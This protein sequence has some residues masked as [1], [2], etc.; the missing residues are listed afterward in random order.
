VVALDLEAA[1]VAAEAVAAHS[2]V[3]GLPDGYREQDPA[4]WISA[5][6]HA[7]REVLETLGDARGGVAGIGI[8]APTGGMVV[9]DESNRIVRPA[10]LGI[11]RSAQRQADE[12][13]RAF[14]GAPGLLELCGNPVEAGSLAAQ[15][16][17]L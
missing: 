12:I 1:S 15:C 8:T 16:L 4:S 11:D 3:E 14:G 5:A 6:D 9:L 2:W 17:W 10:K 13:A 7:M